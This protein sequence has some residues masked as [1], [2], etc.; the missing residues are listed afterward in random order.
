MAL[1]GP[2][3]IIKISIDKQLCGVP[4]TAMSKTLRILSAGPLDGNDLADEILPG[5]YASTIQ[6]LVD[7][8]N[9]VDSADSIRSG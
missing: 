6:N 8:I 7:T 5:A 1:I 2:W 3:Q 4:I 9:Y